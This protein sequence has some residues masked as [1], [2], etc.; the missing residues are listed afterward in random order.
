M[1]NDRGGTRA[2]QRAM[3]TMELRIIN[4]HYQLRCSQRL[5]LQQLHA[6]LH[7]QGRLY[8]GRPTMLSCRM[9]GKRVQF[10]PNGTIQVLAGNMTPLDFVRLRGMIR[11]QLTTYSSVN[12]AA[13]T[14]ALIQLSTWNVNNIVVYFNLSSTYNFNGI[15]CSAHVSYE[16]ELFP[17]LLLAKW[18]TA[19]VTLFPNGKGIVTGVR[20]LFQAMTVLRHVLADVKHWRRRPR[21]GHARARDRGGDDD[22]H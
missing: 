18:A 20:S 14:P 1:R 19:R 3:R 6:V 7:H 13:A 9:M 21:Q 8:N 22:L 2:M 5:N 10:F 15:L 11:E 17:A 4:G 16:P 12:A